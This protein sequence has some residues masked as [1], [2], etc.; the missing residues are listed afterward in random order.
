MTA[1]GG[2]R[3]FRRK[4]MSEQSEFF[5]Q[6]KFTGHPASPP[7]KQAGYITEQSPKS[8]QLNGNRSPLAPTNAERRDTALEATLLQR[9][10]QGNYDA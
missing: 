7:P 4:K 6:A 3:I 1:R 10:D 2:R 5:F 8:D 9:I